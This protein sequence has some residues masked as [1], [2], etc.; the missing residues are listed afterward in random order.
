MFLVHFRLVHLWNAIEV[1]RL[2]KVLTPYKWLHSWS[3]LYLEIWKV[4]NVKCVCTEIRAI[5]FLYSLAPSTI[6][7]VNILLH[8]KK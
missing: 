7:G 3:R 2:C 4:R 1:D 8:H 5:H 6:N